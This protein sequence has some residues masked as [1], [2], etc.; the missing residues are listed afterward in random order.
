MEEGKRY[1]FIDNEIYL[2]GE[3]QPPRKVELFD[4]RV[5]EVNK[6][7][8]ALDED[9]NEYLLD[10]DQLI[11]EDEVLPY[12]NEEESKRVKMCLYNINDK[13]EAVNTEVLQSER[14]YK[15]Y[16]KEKIDSIYNDIKVIKHIVDNM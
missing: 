9:G 4:I 6:T 5:D 16:L 10:L 15:S 11:I 3:K 12:L 1:Y 8:L 13:M 14:A 2:Q 7:F